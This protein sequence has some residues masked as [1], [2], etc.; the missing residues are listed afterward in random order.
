MREHLRNVLT[1]T[2]DWLKF[3]EAK[4]ALALAFVAAITSAYIRGLDIRVLPLAPRILISAGIA[5]LAVAAV[6]AL[7]SFLPT[8]LMPYLNAQRAPTPQD[9]LLYFG[10]LAQYKPSEL[11]TH[12]AA[13]LRYGGLPDPI[14]EHYAAQ[15]VTN[16]RIALRKYRHFTVT[17]WAGLIGVVLLTAGAVTRLLDQA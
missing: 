6:S 16:A 14:D 1:L 8:L 5:S 17:C 2:N 9:N 10:D 7:A 11:L 13:V 4:N 12:T 15:I 3:A